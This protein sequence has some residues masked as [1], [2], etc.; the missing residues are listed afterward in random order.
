MQFQKQLKIAVELIV[1]V[2]PKLPMKSEIL[3]PCTALKVIGHL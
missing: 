3:V 2:N 1:G